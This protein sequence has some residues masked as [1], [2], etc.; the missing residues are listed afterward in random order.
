MTRAMSTVRFLQLSGLIFDESAARHMRD[1]SAS[2]WRDL[3]I[4]AASSLREMTSI[5]E[6][7]RVDAVLCPGSILDDK[8][9]DIALATEIMGRFGA[10]APVPVIIA[11]G[12]NDPVHQFS[13]YDPAYFRR[14]VGGAFPRNVDVLRPGSRRT[15]AALPDV[16]FYA[17][18]A[19]DQL[20]RPDALNILLASE[21]HNVDLQSSIRRF[22]YVACGGDEI[23]HD[24]TDAD[25]NTR[26]AFTS[27]PL[28]TPETRE[29][30]FVIAEVD[31]QTASVKR[32]TMPSS[33]T[34]HLET[35]HTRD[36]FDLPGDDADEDATANK[37]ISGRFVHRMRQLIADASS[38]ST[39]H[40]AILHHALRY[41]LDALSEET[42]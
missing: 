11:P 17:S 10:V 6:E 27:L 23:R 2:R 26:A 20:V 4:D 21:P 16:D 8:S 25:E 13:L 12:K 9:V 22:S 32:I 34:H 36:T 41:G 7:Q 30:T 39:E 18:P 38:D 1:F 33:A 31:E 29:Y 28:L 3:R 15:I 24:L 37:R 40:Q 35:A 5:I 14:K 19:P 42:R